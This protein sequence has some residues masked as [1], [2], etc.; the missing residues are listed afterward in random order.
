MSE[1]PEVGAG[2]FWEQEDSLVACKIGGCEVPGRGGFEGVGIP[3]VS[4]SHMC[5]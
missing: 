3:L 1:R 2:R 4:R 5:P